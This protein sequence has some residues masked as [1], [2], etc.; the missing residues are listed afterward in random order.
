MA[1]TPLLQAPALPEKC[2]GGQPD[3]VATIRPNVI[4]STGET[5]FR[6]V[7]AAADPMP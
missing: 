6:Q 3:A 4:A 7:V 2:G 5:L 1:T